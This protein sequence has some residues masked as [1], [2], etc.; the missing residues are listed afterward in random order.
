MI[1]NENALHGQYIYI[2]RNKKMDDYVIS[3]E[4]MIPDKDGDCMDF[5]DIFDVKEFH[6]IFKIRLK[7]GEQVR[8]P[9]DKLHSILE[10]V[11]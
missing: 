9:L 4:Q 8:I 5:C 6:S 10:P 1:D 2:L 7:K 3:H 11:K